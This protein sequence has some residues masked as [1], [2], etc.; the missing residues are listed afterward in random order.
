MFSMT[1]MVVVDYTTCSQFAAYTAL[2]YLEVSSVIF[3]QNSSFDMVLM[4][5]SINPNCCVGA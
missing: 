4:D 3:C 5:V 1:S 2:K